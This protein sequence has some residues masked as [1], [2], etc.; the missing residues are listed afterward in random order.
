MKKK[1]KYPMYS[2]QHNAKLLLFFLVP[3][4]VINVLISVFVYRD[5]YLRNSSGIDDTMN[6]YLNNL[7]AHFESIERFVTWSVLHETLFTDAG[8][9]AN[10]SVHVS[11]L[12]AFQTR[13]RDFQYSLDESYQF[14]FYLED[15]DFFSNCS[16]LLVPYPEYQNIREFYTRR[17]REGTPSQ[18]DWQLFETDTC[19]YLYYLVTIQGRSLLC[20]VSLDDMVQ[21]LM[22]LNLGREGYVRFDIQE[23]SFFLTENGISSQMP[24]DADQKRLFLSSPD[25]F[26][27]LVSVYSDH[28]S[29]VSR[30]LVLQSCVIAI[31]VFLVV[32]LCIVLLY[33]NRRVIRPIREFSRNLASVN[34]SGDLLDLQSS[35]IIELEQANEQFKNLMREIKKLKISIYEQELEKKRIQMDFMQLQIRPHFYL[36]CLTTIYSMAQTQLYHEIEQMTLITASY[37]RYLLQ[38]NQDFVP[39]SQEVEHIE[40][41][42]AI[43]QLRY[44]DIFQWNCSLD[45]SAQNALIPPLLLQTFVENSVKH[46]V[47][48]DDHITIDLCISRME[49]DGKECLYIELSDTGT[50]FAPDVLEYLNVLSRTSVHTPDPT[51]SFHPSPKTPSW[52]DGGTHIGITNA[53]QRLHLF[54]ED[55]CL[56]R[57]YNRPA[58]GASV[59]LTLPFQT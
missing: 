26:P 6:L 23:H 17:I 46:G 19:S 21:P 48:P 7:S 40:N 2:I 35:N 37:L 39:V 49:K 56:I 24:S 20:Q 59:S 14:Y 13:V 32:A 25:T 9:A 52:S 50:G 53:V 43:Q 28:F 18:L 16:E 51:N 29:L 11:E 41:Y 42:L 33:M 10:P 3:I 55:R 44:G 15:Q 22:D 27:A 47:S 45:A 30:L 8:F 38:N 4:F 1:S 31:A 57:F 36:N 5:T 58:G 34:Q 54:Y 12:T